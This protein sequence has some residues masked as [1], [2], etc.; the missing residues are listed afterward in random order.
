[1][2]F[3]DSCYQFNVHAAQYQTWSNAQKACTA[4]Q[5]AD[6]VSVTNADE[7]SF[8]LKE[9]KDMK[10]TYS[11]I[12]LNDLQREGIFLWSDRNPVEYKNWAAYQ[13]G[14]GFWAQYR[15]CVTLQA[16]TQNGTWAT[17]SCYTSRGYVCKKKR[18][19]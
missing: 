10:K 1:M 13:P 12:G 15:D 2:T 11:W 7:Q 9:L 8:L 5:G 14:T 19:E 18:G 16:N 6:L 4:I 3:G 17:S